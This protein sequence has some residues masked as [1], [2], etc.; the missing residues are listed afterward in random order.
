MEYL[1]SMLPRLWR[2]VT[3]SWLKPLLE[4]G[5]MRR[6]EPSDLF[7]LG[8]RDSAA[9]V[10]RAFSRVKARGGDLEGAKPSLAVALLSAFGGPFFAAGSLKF[11]YDT[12]QFMGPFLL[13]RLIKFLNDPEQP[14]SHGFFLVGCMF[15]VQACMTMCLRQ[16]FWWCYRVGM[17][18]RSAIITSV[19]SKSTVLSMAALS[20]RSTGEITNLMSVDS[21]RLQD[22]TPY[23]HAC[24][25]AVYQMSIAL[26][27]LHNQLGPSAF[28]AVAVILLTIPL[29]GFMARRMKAIQAVVSKL[30]DERVKLSNEKRIHDLRER[31]LAELKKYQFTQSFSGFFFTVTPLFVSVATFAV[32]VSLGNDLDVATALTSLAL[33]DLLRFPLYMLPNVINNLVEA[34]VSVE[35]VESFL[36]EK[37]FYPVPEAPLTEPGVDMKNATLLWDGAANYGMTRMHRKRAAPTV[38]AFSPSKAGVASSDSPRYSLSGERGSRGM[39]KEDKITKEQEAVKYA[40][41]TDAEY[42]GIISQAIAEVSAQKIAELEA[43]EQEQKLSSRSS[44]DPVLPEIESSEKS[45]ILA[46][47]HVTLAVEQSSLVA[48]IG[49][50][51]S[52]K[53]SLISAILGDMRLCFGP[54]Q[55]LRENI[56]FGLPYDEAKYQDTIYQCALQP[57]LETLPAGDQTEIGERGINLSGGQKARVGLARAIYSDAE[58]YL[59]D[60]PLAAATILVTNALNILRHCDEVAI[61]RDGKIQAVGPYDVVLRSSS[62]LKDL[63]TAY[64]ADPS[65]LQDGEEE[66]D[67]LDYAVDSSKSLG[68]AAD[69]SS[70]KSS[71]AAEGKLVMV[72]ER[73]IGQVSLEIYK[74]WSTAAGGMRVALILLVLYFAGESIVVFSSWWLSYWSEHSGSGSAQWYY[75]GIYALISLSAG[76]TLFRRLVK[77]VLFAPMSFYDT[78]PLG[79]IL[80]RFSKDTYTADE[81]LPQTVRWYLGSMAKVI[82]VIIYISTSRELS[83]LDSISRSP[84]YALFSETLDGLNTLRAFAS[85]R[86]L[87]KQNHNMLD[88]Q[89]RAY[90]LNFSANC[91]LGVR[92]EFVGTCIITFASLFAVLG[93][94]VAEGSAFAALAGL[95]ISFALG[96]TQSLN[97]SV[98][99]ASDLESQMVAVERLSEYSR[100]TQEAPHYAGRRGVE[101]S[102]SSNWPSEGVIDFQD[103]KM[104]YREG[105][106]LVLKGVSFKIRSGEKIG[107]VG[108]TGSGNSGT[109]E[110][111]GEDISKLGLHTLRANIAVIAQD[112]LWDGLARAQLTDNF[113]SL[114]KVVEENGSNFSVGERQLI[115]IARALLSESKIIVMDEATAAVDKATC[116]TVAHRLNTILDSDRVLVMDDGLVLEFDSP[117]ALLKDESSSFYHLAKRWDESRD[118]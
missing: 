98:R 58:V 81:Q 84:I 109:I 12:L 28:A 57:D 63:M 1:R 19:F 17:R 108:R 103:V 34:K 70:E 62:V 117:S 53:S 4:T 54:N 69:P 94:P 97:W 14:T 71:K 18:M 2:L 26:F 55:T 45:R 101:A 65:A 118:A 107:I 80:N 16:Y 39:A 31:E 6:L 73:E 27:F 20:R 100:M 115:C 72:E 9:G 77:G 30:R 83:R 44:S 93:R 22:L 35:R 111:D 49:T 99:M 64:D 113:S 24:W 40:E 33:F 85:E 56:L 38:A 37:E 87:I 91:W 86:R 32:Y 11:V 68:S 74:Q 76:R 15:C 41:Y 50:V 42:E 67:I 13:N 23:L 92:L 66:K 8:S 79:R 25:Y 51:G 21:T 112:P 82:G 102:P 105:L 36:L 89:Q 104:R 60:D 3:F 10:Y 61:M 114:D 106:P 43:E 95:S 48:V 110:I 29:T 75:L 116:L 78:T 47:S 59:L 46:L 96:I 5:N 90:F 88:L 7:E 52:G